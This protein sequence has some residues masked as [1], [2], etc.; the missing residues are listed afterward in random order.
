M[1]ESREARERLVALHDHATIVRVH[2]GEQR[3]REREIYH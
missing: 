3:E 2:D 1:M